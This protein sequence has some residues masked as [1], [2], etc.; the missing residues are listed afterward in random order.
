MNQTN[1][2]IVVRHEGNDVVHHYPHI[3]YTSIA[4]AVQAHGEDQI[5]AYINRQHN[6]WTR[7]TER[8]ALIHRLRNPRTEK[9]TA[10]VR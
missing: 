2:V 4:E 5:L 9:T 1:R 10:F 6:E 3:E 7:A 8:A